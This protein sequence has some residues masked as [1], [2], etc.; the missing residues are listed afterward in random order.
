M[1]STVTWS[2]LGETNVTWA[3]EVAAANSGQSPGFGQST[4]ATLFE[5]SALDPAT[6]AGSTTLAAAST[7]ARQFGMSPENGPQSIAIVVAIAAGEPPTD[8]EGVV[9]GA[10]HAVISSAST[11]NKAS[12]KAS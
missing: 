3:T 7:I 2:W 4:R 6:R 9:I 1:T 5:T 10:A 11:G 8:G 12:F